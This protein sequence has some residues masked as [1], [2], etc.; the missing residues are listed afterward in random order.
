MPIRPRADGPGSCK[1]VLRR[2]SRPQALHRTYARIS[3]IAG[4]GNRRH[5][6]LRDYLRPHP[7]RRSPAAPT[8]SSTFPRYQPR[9]SAIALGNRG[10]ACLTLPPH[11]PAAAIDG[12]RRTP[13]RPAQPRKRPLHL[14][15]GS[16]SL[17]LRKLPSCENNAK[18]LERAI[19]SLSLSL[20]PTQRT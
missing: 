3:M 11:P 8:K 2:R 14:Y 5:R 9:L 10:L 18:A 7:R 1:H 20:T 16:S 4:P 19:L 12:L 6:A 13:T 15:A 17:S